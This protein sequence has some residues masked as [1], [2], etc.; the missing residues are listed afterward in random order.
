MKEGGKDPEEEEDSWL[1]DEDT[2]EDD[3]AE[4]PENPYDPSL[5]E[6]DQEWVDRK[7]QGRRSD[8]IL[9]CPGMHAQ[10]SLC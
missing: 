1:G 6:E 7:R 2:Y 8:A 9:S 3:L 5:D 4:L 10:S